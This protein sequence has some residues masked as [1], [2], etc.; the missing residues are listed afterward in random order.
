[1]T[2]EI[3]IL[4]KHAIALAA[5]NGT[6]EQKP[7]PA[8]STISGDQPLTQSYYRLLTETPARGRTETSFVNALAAFASA[9]LSGLAS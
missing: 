8:G 9:F 5:G 4:N 7:L 2:A 6:G 1:M 3:A